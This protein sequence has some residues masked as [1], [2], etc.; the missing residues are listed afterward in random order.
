[1]IEIA[2]AVC[3]LASP[4]RCKDVTLSFEAESVSAYACM[5][6]GQME[7]AQWSNDHPAWRIARYTCRPAGQ[8]ANL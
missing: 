8:V 4:E 3:M 7:L 1:M 2:A 5:S 6:Y